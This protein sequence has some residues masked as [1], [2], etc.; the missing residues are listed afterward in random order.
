MNSISLPAKAG[1][2]GD[3]GSDILSNTVEH[4][5]ERAANFPFRLRTLASGTPE[6]SMLDI[7]WFVDNAA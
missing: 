2:G 6:V 5:L 1:E 4:P 7:N 3:Q